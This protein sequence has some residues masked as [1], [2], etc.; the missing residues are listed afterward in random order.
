[1]ISL[2]WF[3]L[4]SPTSLL[5]TEA[6][7]QAHKRGCSRPTCVPLW[8]GWCCSCFPLAS[9][10]LRNG[11]S[12][13][14]CRSKSALGHSANRCTAASFR[15]TF[16]ARFWG[17]L[18][19]LKGGRRSERKRFPPR[20]ECLPVTLTEERGWLCQQ[21]GPLQSCSWECGLHWVGS[22][23]SAATSW[24][25]LAKA[26]TLV[27]FRSEKRTFFPLWGISMPPLFPQQE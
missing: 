15:L 8:A 14:L 5:L 27:I 1:M 9:T 17:L 24:S 26:T 13:Y 7:Q 22:L 23:L 20:L 19:A 3:T 25:S 6:L 4:L 18:S 21:H 10:F 11:W 12:W 2:N 16:W